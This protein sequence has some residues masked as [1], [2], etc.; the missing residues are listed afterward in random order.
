MGVPQKREIR[1]TA[2]R[3][4]AGKIVT[5]QVVRV[6]EESLTVAVTLRVTCE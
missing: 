4:V 2:R 1:T 3:P 5:W 6:K